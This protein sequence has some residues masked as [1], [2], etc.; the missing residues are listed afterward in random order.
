MHVESVRVIKYIIS[1]QYG[2]VSLPPVLTLSNFHDINSQDPIHLPVYHQ[3]SS[4][5]IHIQI[6]TT[7]TFLTPRTLPPPSHSWGP[8]HVS[9]L[10]IFHTPISPFLI[11]TSIELQSSSL[12][13]SC[14]SSYSSRSLELPAVS[15]SMGSILGL[16][17]HWR[18]LIGIP[19]VERSSA[20]SPWR[21]F[22]MSQFLLREDTLIFFLLIF[23]ALFH[24]LGLFLFVPNKTYG[25]S[26]L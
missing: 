19:G 1:R 17:M 4:F 2:W 12:V 26:R 6:P 9:I 21:L 3:A 8:T 14:T 16:T 20:M 5:I 23:L 13:S 22:L 24:F 25:K 10:Y 11:S 7:L 18:A 15:P